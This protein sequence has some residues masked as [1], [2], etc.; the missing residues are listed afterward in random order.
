MR[1]GIGTLLNT[2]AVVGAGSN[3]FSGQMPP[4]YVPPFSWGS[5][6]DLTEHRLDNFLE[7]AR[8]MHERRQQVLTGPMAGMLS[9]A[10]NA[11][12]GLR[13]SRGVLP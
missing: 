11:T 10:W 9:A 12:A 5:G 2:G 6:A 3:L 4:K 8:T 13:L 1:T 7:T